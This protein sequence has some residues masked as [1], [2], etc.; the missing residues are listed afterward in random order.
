MKKIL[1]F[2]LAVLPLLTFAQDKVK[3]GEIDF[4]VKNDSVNVKKTK[5]YL[6][7]ER[8]FGNRKEVLNFSLVND[9]GT[10]FLYFQL[11]EANSELIPVKCFDSK[12]KIFVQLQNG[13]IITL[14]S[15]SDICSQLVMIP[16]SNQYTRVLSQ[17]FMFA[18]T[19]FEEL[20]NSPISMIRVQYGSER[21]DYVPK[22]S[23]IS[24]FTKLE[25]SPENFFLN[26]LKSIY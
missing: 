25:Y 12:S 15:T 19:N 6:M 5:E 13:K 14:I 8:H 11:I 4:E 2:V 9:N 26:N 20:K 7:E 1:V 3:E 22:K 17:Y 21:K 23:L 18:K 10:L 24:E 16:D